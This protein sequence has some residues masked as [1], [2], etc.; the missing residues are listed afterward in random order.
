VSDLG[1][2]IAA[3]HDAASHPS[4]H[5][6][7][8]HR[9]TIAALVAFAVVAGLLGA[10]AYLGRSWLSGLGGGPD[11]FPGP[12]TGSV[13]VS[14]ESGDS[15]T[16]I[17]QTLADADVVASVGAFVDAAD[18]SPG[19]T[20]IQP[21]TY[22]LRREMRATDA[23]ALLL[24]PSSRQVLK[25]ALPEGL[26]LGESLQTISDTANLPLAE[27]QRAADNMAALPLPPY[28]EG[29]LEGFIFPATYELDPDASATDVLDA[30]I[31]RFEQAAD[32][33]GLVA[34]AQALGYTPLQV[35][36]V[37]SIIE[38]E[39]I[40]PEDF[41]KVARVLYNRLAA[42]QRLELDSTVMYAIG[43]RGDAFTTDEERAIDSPYN[44]YR[45]TGLP[46]GP[47]G[48]PGEA[49]LRAALAPTPGPW[50]YFV[51]V[52]L[53]TGELRFATTFPEH[54]ANV[55]LLQEFCRSSDTC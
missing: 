53:D 16:A 24:D 2:G 54:Q 48:S 22:V 35:V 7:R 8:R 27:V 19:A 50:L 45:V 6:P 37:A 13:S 41:P 31:R 5:P 25:V 29:H 15:L 34:G 46:P 40:R 28:A 4:R 43:E 42:G 11:D 55:A 32:D 10:A 9:G 12:G 3:H 39:A 30:A 23:V 1:L 33:V 52:N 17:G 18:A 26:R 36:T 44:T 38:A 14:I 47:I 49:A 20:G 51:A 21:G